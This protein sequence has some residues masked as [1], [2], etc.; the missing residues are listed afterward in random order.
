[1]D[2]ERFSIFNQKYAGEVV[3]HL[4][5]K[6]VNELFRIDF[7]E[8]RKRNED[9]FF[10]FLHRDALEAVKTYFER[11]RGWPKTSEPIFLNQFGQA[12]SKG[13]VGDAFNVDSR[14][15]KLKPKR[16]RDKSFRTGV[17]CHEA[18]RDVVRS[19]LQRAKAENFDPDVARFMMGHS[20]DQYNYLKFNELEGELVLK[21]AKIASKYLNILSGSIAR[22]DQEVKA[23]GKQ[24]EQLR[25]DL[26]KVSQDLAALKGQFE[27]AFKAKLTGTTND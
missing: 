9:A 15:L 7:T 24:N 14:A 8:G 17:A 11:E 16:Q 21:N 5:E 25:D 3:A 22:N 23:L 13:A 20:V 12:L 19:L 2:R 18:F 4:R 1:M 10:T 6:G 27:T 26:T